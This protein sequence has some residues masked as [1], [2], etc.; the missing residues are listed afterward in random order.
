MHQTPSEDAAL[1]ALSRVAPATLQ[2][3]RSLAGRGTT[4]E[5]MAKDLET[6]AWMS[7]RNATSTDLASDSFMV[8]V[9]RRRAIDVVRGRSRERR[10]LR[11]LETD[12]HRL[13]RPTS[14]RSLADVAADSEREALCRQVAHRWEASLAGR[15]WRAVQRRRNQRTNRGIAE[16]LGVA[17]G[18]AASLLSRARSRLERDLL[19]DPE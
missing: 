19:G 6:L 2:T 11:W 8:T 16:D 9:I 14:S 10:Y 15:A 4:V 13:A 12:A 17:E 3:A 7:L 1:A 18:T 5:E